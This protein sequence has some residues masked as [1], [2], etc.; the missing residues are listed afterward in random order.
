[1]AKLNEIL[2]GLKIELAA[3]LEAMTIERP[4]ESAVKFREFKNADNR[5]IRSISAEARQYQIYFPS[6]YVSSQMGGSTQVLEWDYRITLAYP[7]T[8]QWFE[9][10][11][12]D[13]NNLKWYFLTHPSTV[14]GVGARWVKPGNQILTEK[15]ADDLRRYY[16][17][18]VSVW[19][20]VTY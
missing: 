4:V 19:A 20:A 1:M 6:E 9:A 15:S 12:A 13:A 7:D 10:G 3:N 18:T 11:S 5:D 17:V 16:T 14:A 8:E 2:H